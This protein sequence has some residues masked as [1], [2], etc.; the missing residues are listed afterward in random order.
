[1][2]ETR[3]TLRYWASAA[4]TMLAAC[5]LA[6]IPSAQAQMNDSFEGGPVR[7]RLVESDCR[8]ELGVQELSTIRPHNGNASE[9][10][11][12]KC[13]NGSLAYLAYPIEPTAVIDEF[14]PSAWTICSSGRITLGVN[15][16]FPFAQ[17]PVTGG[18]LHVILWG[19]TYNDTGQWQ[20][21]EVTQIAKRLD[22][23]IIAIRNRFG[24]VNLNLEG[25]YIDALVINAYTGPGRY[26]L[27]LDD[28]N[29]S[30]MIPI[31]DLGQAVP[32]D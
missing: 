15:V 26:H 20:R 32:I 19:S 10:I 7:W 18:R 12:L 17:H 3:T 23:E 22:Q 25:A 13:N 31:A 2:D 21:L 30:G 9:R 8:A 11:E 24:A 4:I 29:L 27:Q 28:L 6:P 16:I 5:L 14:I 1:M